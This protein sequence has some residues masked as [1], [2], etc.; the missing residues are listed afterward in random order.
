MHQKTGGCDFATLNAT[1]EISSKSSHGDHVKGEGD[2]SPSCGV[3]GSSCLDGWIL[4]I[5]EW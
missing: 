2:V 5:D 1:L 4:T 3:G